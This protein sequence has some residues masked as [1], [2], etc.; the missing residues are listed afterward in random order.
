MRWVR[1]DYFGG[2][3]VAAIGHDRASIKSCQ[4]T[5]PTH[6]VGQGA[7]GIEC[8]ADDTEVLSLLKAIE[9]VPTRDR[10]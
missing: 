5:F 9:H 1:C 8:R 4:L 10:A 7:L 3:W 2:G 6:A